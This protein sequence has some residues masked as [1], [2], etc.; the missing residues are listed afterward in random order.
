MFR[1]GVIGATGFIGTPYRKEIRESPELAKLAC[2]CARRRELL[3]AAGAADGVTSLTN[4]W[5]EVVEHPEVDLVLVATPDA[6]HYEAV[7]ASAAANKHVFCEKPVGA[8]VTEAWEMWSAFRRSGLAHFVPFW[9]RFHPLFATARETVQRGALGE[10]RAVVSRWQNPRPRSIPLTWRDDARLSSA[11][12]IADIGSHAYD[13]IRWI[14]GADAVRVFAHG[15]VI[16]PRKPDRGPINLN[17][18]LEW[19]RSPEDASHSPTRHGTAFDHANVSF[20]LDTGAVATMTVSHTFFLRKGLAPEL[21]LHGDEA[22][23]AIDR[24][25]GTVTLFR[26]D[27]GTEVLKT[28]DDDSWGN[29][30]SQHVFPAMSAMLSGKP[31]GHP[32]LEDGYRVQ[33]FT[34]AAATS[35]R[36]G[37]W[38]P[39]SAIDPAASA[40]TG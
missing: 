29:R 37:R 40:P 1:V 16:S 4:D 13:T 20:E 38:I 27:G 8:N 33:L 26:P 9:T 22:S 17:E 34:D 7:M 23:L 24:V 14:L 32:N 15:G 36:E 2:L 30:F 12:S 10:I 11:G 39:L 35:A 3:E 31:T 18:A 28:L 5:R 21:E 25:A 6:L 19:G